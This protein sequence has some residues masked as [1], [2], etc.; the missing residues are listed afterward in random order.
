MLALVLGSALAVSAA[1]YVNGEKPCPGII[2]IGINGQR[3][4]C[5][6]LIGGPIPRVKTAPAGTGGH[7]GTYDDGISYCRYVCEDESYP[8]YYTGISTDPASPACIGTGS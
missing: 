4:I 6:Y 5:N 2:T 1:C 7:T 8:Y 3:V